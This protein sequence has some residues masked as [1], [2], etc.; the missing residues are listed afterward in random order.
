MIARVTGLPNLEIFN[1]NYFIEEVFM[2]VTD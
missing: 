1:K 2:V